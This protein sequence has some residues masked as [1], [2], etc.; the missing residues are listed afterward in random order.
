[1]S[2][3]NMRFLNGYNAPVMISFRMQEL[4]AGVLI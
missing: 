4:T 3:I 1:M 2:R